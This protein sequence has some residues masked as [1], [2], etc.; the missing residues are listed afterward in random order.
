MKSKMVKCIPSV[1]KAFSILEFLTEQSG[2]FTISE[3]SRTFQIPISTTNNLLSSLVVCGYATRDEKGRFRSNMKVLHEAT[4]L[5]EKLEIRDVARPALER[6]STEIGLA[7]TLLIREGNQVVCIDKVEGSSQIKVAASV[8][9]RF[10]LHATA[11]GKVLA[12][13]LPDEEIDRLYPST[14][15]TAV[16]PNTITSLSVFKKELHRVRAQGYAIDDGENVIGIRG[17]AAPIFDHQGM[18]VAAMATGGVGFQLDE[19]LKRVIAAVKTAA[20]AVSEDLGYRP[21]VV[22]PGSIVIPSPPPTAPE[23]RG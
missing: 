13:H 9:K 5:L 6:L 3:V 17:L 20:E 15:L 19:N 2:S 4:R 7:A 16:T 10:E 18:A 22:T 23:V 11:S 21:T 1:R 14:K 8:G 12:S